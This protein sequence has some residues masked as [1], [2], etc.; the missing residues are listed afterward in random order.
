MRKLRPEPRAL[1]LGAPEGAP[2]PLP[3]LSRVQLETLT[4]IALSGWETAPGGYKNAGRDASNWYRTMGVLERLGFVLSKNGSK[5]ITQAGRERV[6]ALRKN[7]TPP[8]GAGRVLFCRYGD[9]SNALPNETNVCLHDDE[10]H[11]PITCPKCR[12]VLGLDLDPRR[13]PTLLSGKLPT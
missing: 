4:R 11:C 1:N 5:R 9:C 12:K 6:A 7:L 3:K 10:C 2:G 8:K 13:E